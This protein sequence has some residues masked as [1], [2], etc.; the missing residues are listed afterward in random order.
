MSFFWGKLNIER[1]RDS[2]NKIGR[3]KKKKKRDGIQTVFVLF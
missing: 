2:M 1:K 3:R